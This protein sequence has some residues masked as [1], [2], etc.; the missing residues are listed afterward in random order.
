MLEAIRN[1][2]QGRLA[3]IILAL[4]TIP[5]ALWGIDSYFNNGGREPAVA[6]VDGDEISQRDFVRALKNQRDNLEKQGQAKIDIE[7][8]AFREGVLKQIINTR[9]LS[10]A[11]R[12]VGFVVPAGEMEAVLQRAPIFQSNG[13]FSPERFDAW[14]REQGV[15]KQELLRMLEEDTL[16]R[17][18][19]FGYGEGAIAPAAVTAQV[20]ALVA[21]QREVIE[22]IFDAAAYAKTVAVDDKAVEAEYNAHKADFAYPAQA[23]VQYL[24]LSLD[25]IRG[26][27][28]ISDE[29]ARQYYESNAARY[30]SPEQRRASHI[31]IK[32]DASM[33]PAQRDAAKAKASKLMQEIQSAPN[34]FA[35]LARQQSQDPGSAERGGDL[36]SFSRD[37]MVKPFA[38]A[39]FSMKPGEVRGPVESEFG[40]HIIR[41][42][43]I[44]MGAK[45][46]FESVKAEI[47]DGL[48]QQE[49]QRQF[50][51]VADRFGNLVYEKPDSLDPA[52]KALQLSV[53]ESGWISRDR[54]EPA[55]LAN[56]ALLD[57]VF[58]PD[59][60][61][62]HQ[63]TEAIEVA[64]STL[65]AARVIEQKP[66][67]T[68]PLA[69]VTAEIRAKL[70]Q[71]AA[72]AKAIEAGL[73]A[74]KSLQA[75][76]NVAGMS[77]PRL[78]SRMQP[79]GLPPESIKAVFKANASKLPLAV[80]AETP[81][82]YRL[83]RVNRVVKAEAD[84]NRQKMLQRDLTRL[85]AQEELRAYLEYRRAHA[86]VELNNKAL[87]KK[88][89]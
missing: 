35:E 73:Q 2:A 79:L 38:D 32:A 53:Q 83:Y 51:E 17:Q 61:E 68:R 65:V 5:F 52:A 19:Q 13:K 7:D 62:K 16:T 28:R 74:F 39:V 10:G 81:Q 14:L 12:G 34:R 85:L 1:R 37:M 24:V 57:A 3:Q 33:T 26:Q 21:Q 18:L 78:V 67:G 56:K 75:G 36:G 80:G 40:Y 66:A 44:A 89:E 63:N 25:A 45:L 47:V 27:I 29:A 87:D 88:A 31:L 84:A 20:A 4:I 72:R 59:A 6:S 86:K 30:Q 71:Q 23:R 49:A 11:A 64:P 50:A 76:Q 15:G 43:G 54:A 69:D 41:L 48:T 22:V 8:K 42:D 9:L 77:A 58:S 46:A 60:L 55:M 82:G 70:T